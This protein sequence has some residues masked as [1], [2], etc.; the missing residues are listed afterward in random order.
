MGSSTRTCRKGKVTKVCKDFM[1]IIFDE[2]N[3]LQEKYNLHRFG[4]VVILD[5]QEVKYAEDR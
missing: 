1:D 5:K 4:L 3:M 2:L